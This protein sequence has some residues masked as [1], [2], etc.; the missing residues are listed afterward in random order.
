MERGPVNDLE[1]IHLLKNALTGECGNR[2]IIFRGLEYSY[3]YEGPVRPEN[4]SRWF[5]FWNQMR[6]NHHFCLAHRA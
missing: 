2:E 6:Q 1:I 5:I 3:Y 4:W